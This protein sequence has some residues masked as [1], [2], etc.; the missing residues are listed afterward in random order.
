MAGK[1]VDWIKAGGRMIRFQ[2]LYTIDFSRIREGMKHVKERLSLHPFYIVI[3]REVEALSYKEM[4]R[5]MDVPIGTVMSR[6]SRA[7]QAL[8]REVLCDEHR[9][10]VPKNGKR[11]GPADSHEFTGASQ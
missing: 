2:S 5:I 1:T 7:R 8:Q 3:L 9:G 10:L 11:I 6:L 4:A